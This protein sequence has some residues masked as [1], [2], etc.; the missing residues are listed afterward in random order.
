MAQ[1]MFNPMELSHKAEPLEFIWHRRD[2]A[3]K[4]IFS[5]FTPPIAFHNQILKIFI[6]S[7]VLWIEGKAN[8][9]HILWANVRRLQTV[10]D[11]FQR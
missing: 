6:L 5:C 8:V 11:G 4:E 10:G 7:P 2:P 3:V 9:G 1:V